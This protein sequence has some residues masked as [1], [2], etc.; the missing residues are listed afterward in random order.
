MDQEQEWDGHV[1]LYCDGKPMKLVK[2]NWYPH[3]MFNE[4]TDIQILTNLQRVCN[5]I[6]M[7]QIDKKLEKKMCWNDVRKKL[8]EEDQNC[9]IG[10]FQESDASLI[11]HRAFFTDG[12]FI[13]LETNS[14]FPLNAQKWMPIPE[15]ED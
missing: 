3:Y 8:P 9:L 13:S 7:D 4:E 15:D 1:K 12:C 10:Y 6:L 14:A 11:T 2:G 5:R